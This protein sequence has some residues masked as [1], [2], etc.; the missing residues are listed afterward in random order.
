MTLHLTSTKLG[1]EGLKQLV[2][3]IDVCKPAELYLEWCGFDEL[4]A[5]MQRV[6]DYVYVKDEAE[7]AHWTQ[8]VRQFR[9]KTKSRA[10]GARVWRCNHCGEGPRIMKPRQN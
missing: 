9:A 8:K 1:D 10:K 2:D 7:V 4:S 5:Q 6:V 3:A